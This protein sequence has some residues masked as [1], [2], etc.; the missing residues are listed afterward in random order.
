MLI[1]TAVTCDWCTNAV[2]DL[3]LVTLQERDEYGNDVTQIARPLPVEYLLVDFPVA[4]PVE[5]QA[6]FSIISQKPFPVE[7]RSEI[8]DLQVTPSTK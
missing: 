7:N 5:P 2:T 6:T 4:F 1:V 3:W 8:G